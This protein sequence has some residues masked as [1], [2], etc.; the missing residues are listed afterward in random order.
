[1]AHIKNLIQNE[2]FS[3][4]KGVVGNEKLLNDKIL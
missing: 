3:K 2:N 1:M 4:V